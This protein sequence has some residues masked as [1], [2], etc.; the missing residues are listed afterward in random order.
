MITEAKGKHLAQ[1]NSKLDNFDVAPK[2]HWFIINKLLNN[3]EILIITPAFF[4][5]K[6]ISDFEKKAELFNN[7]F[8]L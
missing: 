1:L 3:K 6:L 7:H 8:V 4:E 2:P 5:D